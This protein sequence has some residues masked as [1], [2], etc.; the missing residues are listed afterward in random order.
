MRVV[1]YQKASGMLWR[2]PLNTNRLIL[3]LGFL[4]IVVF[5]TQMSILIR[6]YFL[7]PLAHL[8]VM[9]IW[10]TLTLLAGII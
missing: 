6:Q 4:L 5:H 10:M 1:T 8:S 2:N 7:D 3:L 9:C